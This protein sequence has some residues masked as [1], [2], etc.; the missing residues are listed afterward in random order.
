ME[1]KDVQYRICGKHHVDVRRRWLVQNQILPEAKAATIAGNTAVHSAD[2][3]ADICLFKLGLFQESD[4]AHFKRIYTTFDL[5]D[6]LQQ[7]ILDALF[8]PSSVMFV[9]LLNHHASMTGCLGFKKDTGFFNE[10]D[11]NRFTEL[12]DEGIAV[13][14]DA[15]KGENDK[16]KI[17]KM[18]GEDPDTEDRHKE[19][20]VIRARAGIAYRNREA[21]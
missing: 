15:E 19:M 21:R 13:V 5:D 20:K 18:Y 6:F 9:E 8:A 4:K 11:S 12:F 16:M 10:T 14:E 2:L 1:S 17:W 3:L 7:K